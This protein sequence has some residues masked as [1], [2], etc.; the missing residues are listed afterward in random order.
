MRLGDYEQ[1]LEEAE[2]TVNMSK[3]LAYV[4]NYAAYAFYGLGMPEKAQE[5]LRENTYFATEEKIKEKLM[6]F[7]EFEEN[8]TILHDSYKR[9]ILANED[10][11]IRTKTPEYFAIANEIK[12]SFIDI[13][14]NDVLFG[15]TDPKNIFK[16]CSTAIREIS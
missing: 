4:K 12:D 1:A 10:E 3:N 11:N 14:K 8:G 13:F 9:W 7:N 5:I 2:A 6:S 15:L 16:E